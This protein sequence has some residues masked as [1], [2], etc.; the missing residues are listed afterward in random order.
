MT[1]PEHKLTGCKSGS[2]QKELGY[3]W[4]RIAFEVVMGPWGGG[5]QAGSGWRLKVAWQLVMALGRG[6]ER[7]MGIGDR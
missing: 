6:R 7:L 1:C 4:R 5:S 3:L 2:R